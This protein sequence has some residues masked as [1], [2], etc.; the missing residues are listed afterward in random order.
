MRH[1]FF[2][3]T[4]LLAWCLGLGAAQVRGQQV[5]V[6]ADYH[7]RS[8]FHHKGEGEHKIG[9]GDMTR[10]SLKYN[11][12]LS[13]HFNEQGQPTVWALSVNGSYAYLD[14]SGQA[15]LFNPDKVLNAGVTVSFLTPVN[16]KWTLMASL[17]AGLYGQ[18]DHIR[19][20]TVLANG[21]CIFACR[22]TERLTVGGGAGLTNAF[23][24]PMVMPM[25]FLN[26]KCDGRYQLEVNCVNAIK[27]TASTKFSERFKLT[28]NVL[29]MDNILAVVFP[30]DKAKIYSSM[31]LKSYFSPEYYIVP[32]LRLSVFGN[33]GVDLVRTSRISDRKIGAMFS[34]FSKAS[35]SF[36]PAGFFSLGLRYGF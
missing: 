21:S 16:D 4:M 23:G 14:D 10:L 26:W 8:N 17:G 36:K 22:V 3:L 29:E 19:W 34:N 6:N 28:W 12:P 32:R 20:Q 30:D 11:Q 27:A 1:K 35:H 24:V 31:M 9:H 5:Q 18:G 15:R 2:T 25:F 33:A 13:L 7:T